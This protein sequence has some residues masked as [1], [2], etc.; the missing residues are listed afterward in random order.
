MMILAMVT[1]LV[2][3][4][5][6]DGAGPATTSSSVTTTATTAPSTTTSVPR[7]P[8]DDGRYRVVNVAAD[9]VL[10][11]R[12]S[13]GADQPIVGA[14]PANGLVMLDGYSATVNSS[15]WLSVTLDDGTIGWV[16]GAF[17]A[18]PAGWELPLGQVACSPDGANYGGTQEISGDGLGA[19]AGSVLSV[20]TYSGTDCNRIVLVLGTGPELQN[21]GRSSTPAKTVPVGTSVTSGGPVV[22]IRIPGV[23]VARPIAQTTEA[24]FGFVLATRDEPLTAGAGDLTLRAFFDANQQAAVTWLTEPARVVID[25]RPAPTG[26]GLDVAAKRS[27]TTVVMPIQVDVNGPGVST[28]IEVTGWGRPFEAQGVAVLRTAGDRPGTG[29]LVEATFSGTD[30]AGTQATAQYPYMT[31]DY[32]DAWGAFSFTIDGLAP[33]TYELFVGDFNMESGEPEGVHQTFTVAN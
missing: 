6:D 5:S 3:C 1:T 20:F 9:D 18:P 33:G 2:A 27:G 23:T 4:G 31:A 29:D 7:V 19:G 8:W 13:P 17:L 16:N 22:E 26:T 32:T 25:I 14:L 28:P 12:Q 15:R 10:N 11:V 21:A 30:F 24:P